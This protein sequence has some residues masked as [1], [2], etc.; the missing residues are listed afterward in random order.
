MEFLL[1]THMPNWLWADPPFPH[2][3]FVSHRRLQRQKSY[4]RAT[5]DWAL[6]SGGFTEL[7]MFGRW[8][9]TVD[10]YVSSV[11]RYI[12]EIGRLM[13][14][15]PMDWMC[16]PSM[17]VKTGLTVRQHQL[18]TV[19]NFLTL[20]RVAP[21][22]PF[23]PVLQ[24]W[25]AGDYLDHFDMYADAG[26]DLVVEPITGM[27]TFCRRAEMAPI[28]SLVHILHR[29]G[30]N[31][32]GFGLKKDGVSLYGSQLASTD[33]LA[34]SKG[35]RSRGNLCGHT[36]RAKT[37]SSCPRWATQWADDVKASIR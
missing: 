23:I 37:C 11:R 29:R 36:H 4:K 27:G 8:V 12:A 3:L 20:R 28:R 24:G 22:L 1:T 31:M 16:E 6:D 9:E 17:L 18:R 13:W 26:I 21:D 33:S 2:K 14:A 7:S 30:V 10:H 5:V 15:A 19:A 35:G 25:E 32:H 34:W